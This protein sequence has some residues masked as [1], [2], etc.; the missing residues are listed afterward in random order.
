MTDIDLPLR[1]IKKIKRRQRKGKEWRALVHWS[2]ET[3][4][5][6]ALKATKVMQNF[7]VDLLARKINIFMWR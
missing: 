3:N 6:R 2:L 4:S 5:K 1:P 7:I